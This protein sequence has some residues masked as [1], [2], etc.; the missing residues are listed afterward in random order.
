MSKRIPHFTPD[1]NRSV[2]T[3]WPKSNE[4]NQIVPLNSSQVNM[5]INRLWA[6][7]PVKKTIS[8]TK[9]RKATVTH[10]RAENPGS[11][12]N[13]ARHMAHDPKTAEKYYQVYNSHQMAVP[14]SKLITNVMENRKDE[15]K[16]TIHWPKEGQTQDGQEEVTPLENTGGSKI[17]EENEKEDDN[18]NSEGTIDY[19]PELPP[20][21][22]LNIQELCEPPE[23]EE[24]QQFIVK[25]KRRFF[26]RQES[27]KIIEICADNINEGHLTSSAIKSSIERRH[28]Q[29][30]SG[31]C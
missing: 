21:S 15:L 31:P 22:P 20:Q 18:E 17:I 30:D 11:R 2:F 5:A 29:E 28:D 19:D 10:V 8:A 23:E 27:I 25:H 6:Q 7:G 16:K 9:L 24:E 14:M 12:E 1:D 26:D 4:N 3:T 13:L